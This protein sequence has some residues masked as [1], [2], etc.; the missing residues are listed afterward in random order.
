MTLNKVQARIVDDLIRNGISVIHFNDLFPSQR[1]SELQKLTEA[2][3]R[4]NNEKINAIQGGLRPGKAGKFY[5]VRL[6]GDEPVLDRQSPF[7]A[8]S[9]SDEV[10]AVVCRYLGMFSRVIDMDLWCNVPTEGPDT[11]SQAWHRDPDDRKL[12]K[13]FLYLQDVGETTGPFCYIPG[14]HNGGP[15]SR[16]F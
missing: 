11:Y 2:Y 6:L 9:L 12:V 8:L 1:F 14:S 4:E 13:T 7:V 16:T 3:L 10:L 15:F 5:L